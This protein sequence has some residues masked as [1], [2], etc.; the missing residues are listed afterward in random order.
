MKKSLII[1]NNNHFKEFEINGFF[2]IRNFLIN[3][4]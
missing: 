4:Y 2:I 1:K 3:N